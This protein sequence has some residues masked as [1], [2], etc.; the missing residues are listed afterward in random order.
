ML[1]FLLLAS[2]LLGKSALGDFEKSLNS[3]WMDEFVLQAKENTPVNPDAFAAVFFKN[4]GNDQKL[5]QFFNGSCYD[6]E[7]NVRG[8]P[9]DTNLWR[10]ASITKM[11]TATTAFQLIEQG[12]LNRTAP[13]QQYVPWIEPYLDGETLLIQDLLQH[14]TS[15]DEI[16][17]SKKKPV[18]FPHIPKSHKETVTKCWTNFINSPGIQ[19]GPSYS[20]SGWT[21]LGAVIEEITGELLGDYLKRA[22]FKPLDIK[23]SGFTHQQDNLNDLCFPFESHS[24]K[25]E[26]YDIDDYASG[27]LVSSIG[28]V[29]KFFSSLLQDGKGIYEH[30]ET[31]DQSRAPMDY[32][33]WFGENGYRNGWEFETHG[34]V[35]VWTKGGDLM[36]FSSLAWIIPEFNE[37]G[38][39]VNTPDLQYRALALASFLKVL[40]PQESGADSGVFTPAKAT[41]ENIA[42]T[43]KIKLS[44]SQKAFPENILLYK[45]VND[46]K[47]LS[48]QL[49]N[50]KVSRISIGG[51]TTAYPLSFLDKLIIVQA[52][53]VMELAAHI[54][55]GVLAYSALK[56][57]KSSKAIAEEEEPLLNNDVPTKPTYQKL[58]DVISLFSPLFSVVL[59][60]II[61]H[62][63]ANQSIS[64][65]DCPILV[66]LEVM[67]ILFTVSAAL[68]AL[69]AAVA[70]FKKV[71]VHDRW[72]LVALV[73]CKLIGLIQLVNLNL[74]QF[75]IW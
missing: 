60:G 69:I 23:T 47:S 68:V 38:V 57:W 71:K 26:P 16:G 14:T 59:A 41:L 36:G 25:L 31:V 9:S 70:C 72:I 17:I 42:A 50:G 3:K 48:V 66:A 62:F 49:E 13:V 58:I 30:Q 35:K 2:S 46:S 12:L 53:L 63:Y 54:L 10:F 29:A 4:E 33:L 40:H 52:G 45:P 64:S 61:I 21:L 18:V 74:V 67:L 6:L 5:V 8:V 55:M 37:G 73:V 22:I 43:Q 27:D 75:R 1:Q 56:R 51:T 39:F 24:T 7:G 28:D 44:D 32:H 15:F 65:P 19:N 20:N 34:K 11:Y